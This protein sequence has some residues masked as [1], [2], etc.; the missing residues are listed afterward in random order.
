MELQI[1]YSVCAE[2]QKADNLWP[3]SHGDWE[4]TEG[5]VQEKGNRDS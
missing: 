4:D 2:V 1:S 3:T 5:A